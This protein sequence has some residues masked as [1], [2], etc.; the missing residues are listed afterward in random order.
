[1]HELVGVAKLVVVDCYILCVN[2]SCNKGDTDGFEDG[3]CT[4]WDFVKWRL[5]MYVALIIAEFNAWPDNKCRKEEY[6]TKV[7]IIS[8]RSAMHTTSDSTVN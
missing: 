3:Y 1:M 4:I 2:Q 7:L 6:I 8:W 5:D